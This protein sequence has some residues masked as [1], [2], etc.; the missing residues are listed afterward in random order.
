MKILIDIGHPAHVHLF[1][2]FVQKMLKKG[3][4]VL[5]TCRD[6]EFEIYLLN[7]FGFKFKSFGKK[8]KSG[9]GKL[10][11]LI[12]FD[13]KEL[14][15]GLQFRP[16]IFVSHGS[17]YA[18]HAAFLLGKPHISLEDTFNFEQIR[19]YK[20]FTKVILT[21]DYDHPLK[22]EKVIRYAGY[23]ELAYLHPN[24]FTPDKSVLK[25]LGVE[26]DENYII[27]RFVSWNASHDYGHTGISFE[28]KIKAVDQFS[29][30]AKVFISSEKELPEELKKYQFKIAPEKMHDAIAFSSLV[31]GESSTMAEEAAMLGVPSIY[32]NNKSTFYTKH[33]EKDYNLV[34]NYAESN[35]DQLLAIAKGV[36]LLQQPNIKKQWQQKRDKMLADKIDVTAFLA[37]FVEKYPESKRILKESPEYQY[38]F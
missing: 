32:L 13:I 6:K 38:N 28:N 34:F 4:Q 29:K 36:E 33:L 25:E 2:F 18:A 3:H 22:S 11:G 10:W 27:I 37:W 5:F 24:R 19:L 35:N 31:F 1:R 14:I 16:D 30:H 20:P 12:E 7:K 9:I 15:S 26:K 21:A 8:Y 23:H 17:M